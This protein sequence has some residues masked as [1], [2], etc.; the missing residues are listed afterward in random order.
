M[1]QSPTVTVYTKDR[2][3]P[4]AATKRK[5]TELGIAFTER[6]VDHDERAADHLR[7]SGFQAAPVV[8]T[9]TDSWSGYDPARIQAYAE[10]L[11]R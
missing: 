3:Q 1:T 7:A 8:F 2:C 11:E 4:C 6:N 10:S 5:L 9:E